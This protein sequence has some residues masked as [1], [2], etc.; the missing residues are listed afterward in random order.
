MNDEIK[1]GDIVRF[2]GR[3]CEAVAFCS[4]HNI[5]GAIVNLPPTCHGLFAVEVG[6]DYTIYAPPDEIKLVVSRSAIPL[7][8]DVVS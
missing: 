6:F 1:I 8:E 4:Q 7:L 2:N 5:T 3:S